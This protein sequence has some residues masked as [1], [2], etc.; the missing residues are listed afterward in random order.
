MRRITY[1]LGIALVFTIPWE[2][3]TSVMAFGSLTKIMGMI[4]ALFWGVTILLEGKFR[5][6][7]LFHALVFL[8]FLWNLV[9]VIW[10]QNL[11]GT[12]QRIKTYGQIFILMLI[13]WEF[14]QKP[15]QLSTALQAYVFGAYVLVI[16]SIYNYMQGSV[17]VAYEGRYSATGVN[18]NDLTLILLL[19]LPVAIQLFFSNVQNKQNTLLRVVN[20]AYI[21]LAIFAI[22]LTG[23]R[24]S[25]IAVIPFGFYLVGTRQ[26]KPKTKL[27]VVSILLVSLL[28]LIPFI[29]STLVSRLGTLGSSIES[30]DL[31][32][33]FELWMEALQVFSAHPITGLGS[34]TLVSA[35]GSAAHNTF[36][37]VLAETGVVGFILFLLILAIV[38]FQALSIPNGNAG[39]W[40]AIFLTWAIGVFSLSW[41]FRK[42][43]WLFLNFIAIEGSFTY[44]Q[45]H[46][47]QVGIRISRSL[48]QLSRADQIENN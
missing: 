6:P 1:V 29:P 41:E 20:L 12:I 21:P 38:F 40:V 4:V 14:F 28:A 33:R 39:L 23:S 37:S 22:L 9:S 48:R 15:E 26:I 42:L 46:V 24:T 3:S 44:E 19:G 35:I 2:D 45:L 47:K 17:A 13:F 34:G 36:V 43:T 18:A 10:S 25:L 16:N 7:R 11:D 31:G 32:G 30:R 5:R 8:F 27:L